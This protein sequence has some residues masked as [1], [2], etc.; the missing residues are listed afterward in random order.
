[1]RTI[2]GFA[3]WF[4]ASSAGRALGAPDR[5]P[6]AAD[7]AVHPSE[8]ADVPASEFR[9]IGM[10]SSRG[11]LA[12][13][14]MMWGGG[15]RAEQERFQSVGWTLDMLYERGEIT[16]P[17]GPYVI[18]TATIGAGLFVFQHWSPVSAR[19]GAGVRAGL[20]RSAPTASAL[21]S[22]SSS[23]APWGWP[24]LTSALCLS[25]GPS[26]VVELSGEGSYV[27]LSGGSGRRDNAL[28]GV[29]IGGQLG[30]GI[31]PGNASRVEPATGRRHQA[32]ARSRDL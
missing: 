3:V 4:L 18:D 5:A 29:W 1:V 32:R 16:S 14:G 20:A 15:L 25:L 23:A 6:A 17:T 28:S 10:V 12:H 9:L 27:V 30:L 2:V 24:M 11:F 26:F 21:N 7:A 13:E 31:V 19:I 22:A 8:E